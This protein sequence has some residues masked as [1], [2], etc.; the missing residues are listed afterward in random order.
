MKK[1]IE[2]YF[3]RLFPLHRSI[4]GTGYRKSLD[5]LSE[6]MPMKKI[7]F[8]TGT[9]VFDWKI[10]EEWNVTH[11]TL[12]DQNNKKI[13][14]FKDNNLHL[15]GY[16]KKFKKMLSFNELK[17]HLYYEKKLPKAIPYI[18]SYYKKRWGFCLSYNHFKKLNKKIKYKV[19]INTKF[20]NGKLRIGENFIKGKSNKEIIISSYLCHP[21]MANNEL[22][23]PLTLVFL[24]NELKKMN[25]YYSIRFVINPEGIGA[26]SYLSRFKNKLKNNAIGGYQIT[27]CGLNDGPV[28]KKTKNGNSVI[29]IAMQ[30]VLQKINHKTFNFYPTGSDECRYNSLGINIMFGTFMRCRV[31]SYKE[32]HTS[33]DNKKIINFSN[34][35]KNVNILKRTILFI[36]T[37]NFYKSLNIDCD[38]FL[39]KRNIY[40][41]LSK[42][43]SFKRINKINLAF[44]WLNSYSDGRISTYEIAKMSKIPIKIIEIAAKILINKK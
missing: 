4:T 13:L 29:D 35:E 21:S 33:L 44:F 34:M 30:K 12:K 16:S 6:I 19:D 41:S 42:F 11:A 26:I 20:S 39:S 9:K 15:L 7:D 3:D 1:K 22:S 2:K 18:T 24:Y 38:P 43:N 10:P 40:S 31:D 14:D 5:I 28:Y 25:L 8:K 17:K 32:Y 23:G 37:L 36:N 27:C